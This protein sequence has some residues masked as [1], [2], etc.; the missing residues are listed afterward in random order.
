MGFEHRRNNLA[1]Q[2]SANI[3]ARQITV[4]PV[5]PETRRPPALPIWQTFLPGLQLKRLWL[6]RVRLNRR[7]SPQPAE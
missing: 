5:Y 7:T 1:G 3:P 6:N 2:Q 4:R